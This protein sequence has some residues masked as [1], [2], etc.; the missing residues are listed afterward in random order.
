MSDET[1][2]PQISVSL[3]GLSDYSHQER[4]GARGVPSRHFDAV[5]DEAVMGVI[6]RP[7][8][9]EHRPNDCRTRVRCGVDSTWPG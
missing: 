9:R 1:S 3:A 4:G 8:I 6:R 2:S 5:Y 7:R